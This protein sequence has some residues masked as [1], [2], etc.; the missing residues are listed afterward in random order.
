MGLKAPKLSLILVAV[1]FALSCFGFTLFVWK[2]FGGPTPLEAHGYQF[3]ILFGSEAS[4]LA[5]NADVRIS[6]VNVGKV[7]SVKRRGLGADATVQMQSR[8]A[9]VPKDTRAI[10]RFKTL[11]GETFVEMTPGSRTAPKLAENGTL[12][13]RQVAPV[14]QVDRVLGAFDAPT[15]AAFKRFLT[16]SAAA[17]DRRGPDLNAAIGHLA[18]TTESAAGL[19]EILDR[20]RASLRG[21]VRDSGTALS[22]IGSRA[23]DLQSLVR[24]SNQVFQAT[25]QRNDSLTATVKAFPKFLADARSALVQVDGAAKDAA[26]TLAALRP[27]IPLIVPALDETRML[28]PVTQHLFAGLGPVIRAGRTG[29]PAVTR[30]LDAAKPTVDVL[31]V[32]ATYLVPLADYLK[33][34]RTDVI[35]WLAKLSSAANYRAPNGQRMARLLN[36]IDEEAIVG[37]DLRNASNRH[38]AYTAPG[39]IARLATT[40]VRS[41]DCR[42]TANPQKVPVVGSG[43]PACV[44]QPPFAFRGLTRSFP[45]LVPATPLSAATAKPKAAD[46]SRG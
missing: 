31:D 46:R 14:Q 20:Q 36:P 44:V 5:P 23:A 35:T 45:H 12:A 42:N 18:P 2:A 19:L 17:L 39:E 33:R 22:A 16:R 25:A 11:L 1:V 27:V 15:R 9:P 28:A 3:H 30:V 13:R 40:S 34:Y 21:L 6:G 41:F 24:A 26:P 37:Y 43:T 38:N 4:Q 29:L 8:F 10:I 7:I 32:A